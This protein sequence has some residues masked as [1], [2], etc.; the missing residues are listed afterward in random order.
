MSPTETRSGT[1]VK[2][3][4]RL[5]A[6]AA[7]VAT[8]ATPAA[9]REEKKEEWS[10]PAEEA[11]ASAEPAAVVDAEFDADNFIAPPRTITDVAALLEQH[12]QTNADEVARHREIASAEPPADAS[13]G[14][15]AE[16][17]R[18][19]GVAAGA[20]GRV[21]DQIDDLERALEFAERG[22]TNTADILFNLGHAHWAAGN[23]R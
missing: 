15:L 7:V 3:L 13:D 23:F 10:K 18:K 22:G 19:R 2:R 9:A 12:E 8:L 17:Y 11:T 14:T 20:L 6:S 4:G 16:F 5:I 1:Y 21:K